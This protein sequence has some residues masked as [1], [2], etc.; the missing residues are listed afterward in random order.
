MGKLLDAVKAKLTAIRQ[1]LAVPI[2]DPAVDP[3]GAIAAIKRKNALRYLQTYVG[4]DLLGVLRQLPV[5][6]QDE[7]Y[8]SFAAAGG[9]AV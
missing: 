6:K 7:F 1:E 2:P 3:A 9:G 5:E 8:D 4:K